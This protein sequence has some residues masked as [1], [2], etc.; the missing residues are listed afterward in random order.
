MTNVKIPLRIRVAAYLLS[1]TLGAAGTILAAVLA[2]LR[3][4]GW[5]DAPTGSMLG[6]VV[7]A[8]LGLAAVLAST[9]ALSHLTLPDNVTGTTSPAPAPT[10]SARKA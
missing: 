3:A 10:R 2:W 6:D 9:L 8:L 5:V 7:A 4:E 1:L